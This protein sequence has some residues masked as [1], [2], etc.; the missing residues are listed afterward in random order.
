MPPL[1]V[2]KPFPVVAPCECCVGLSAV[3]NHPK[4]AGSGLPNWFGGANEDAT[5]FHVFRHT[6]L[7]AMIPP[8]PLHS[9]S[10][11]LQFFVLHWLRVQGLDSEFFSDFKR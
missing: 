8:L 10:P 4:S 6:A 5:R 2:S 11:M 9:A 1:C 7:R 3:G